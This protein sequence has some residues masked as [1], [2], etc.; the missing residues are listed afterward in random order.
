MLAISEYLESALARGFNTTILGSWERSRAAGLNPYEMNVPTPLEGRAYRARLEARGE[1]VEL[2][3]HF[4][5][6]F[7]GVLDQLGAVS[8]VCDGEGYLL[9]RVGVAETLRRF[10]HVSI[11]EGSSCSEAVLGTNAPGLALV[12]RE[13]V[14]VTADEHY[15]RLYHTAFCVA[16]PILDEERMPIGCIDI[17][18][19]F[20]RNDVSPAVRKDLLQLAISLTDAIRTELSLRKLG[21]LG[22]AAPRRVEA[23]VVRAGIA[24]RPCELADRALGVPRGAPVGL[25]LVPPPSGDL[26]DAIDRGID[27][28]LTADPDLVDY[29]RRRPG[30]TATALPWDHRY[31]LMLPSGSAGVGAAIPADTT[32]LRSALADG[33]VRADARAAEAG[34]FIDDKF[35]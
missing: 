13:A 20:D 15:S 28:V 21:R 9:S 1:M 31:V 22:P 3:Q 26:R 29:A 17:T 2:F 12:T 34:L 27:L 7:A 24:T 32:A 10:D 19:F 33:A 11:R 5:G 16:A 4:T 14:M 25:T 8:F 18:K 35:V 30:A 6:R 23:R